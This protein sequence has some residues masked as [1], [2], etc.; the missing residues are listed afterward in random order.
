M[1]KRSDG[2]YQ[3][4]ITLPNGKTKLL[5]SSANTEREAIKK[6]ANGEYVEIPV[7]SDEYLEF[8]DWFNKALATASY[9]EKVVKEKK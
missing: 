8:N 5:Y 2:R 3:K 4:R 7:P 1:K 6:C 9:T